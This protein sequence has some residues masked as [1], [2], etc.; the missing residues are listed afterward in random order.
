V[1]T[2]N[3]IEQR[4]TRSEGGSDS[5]SNNYILI[6]ADTGVRVGE[7]TGLAFRVKSVADQCSL[8]TPSTGL[9]SAGL[10]RRECATVTECT[11]PSSDF[12]Q[13]SK[14][15]CSSGKSGQRS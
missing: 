4:A 13:N 8:K 6:L 14:K 15:L 11:T 12:C 1:P 10:M 2:L 5:I 7:I 9:I 3:R